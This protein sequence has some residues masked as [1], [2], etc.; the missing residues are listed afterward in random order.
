MRN[1]LFVCMTALVSACGSS[2][3]TPDAAA[4]TTRVSLDTELMDV[5][6][7]D[8]SFVDAI[9]MDASSTTDLVSADVMVTPDG[10][11]EPAVTTQVLASCRGVSGVNET[12][13]LIK[14]ASACTTTRCSKLVVVFAGGEQGCNPT[15]GGYAAVIS[16]YAARGWASIC[17]N[18]FETSDGSAMVPYAAEAPRLD[19][20]MREATTGTWARQYW[21]GEDLLI[22]GISH[23][24]TAPI[25]LMARTTLDNAPHW[26]GTR[27]SGVCMFDGVYDTQAIG[28]FLRTG[29]SGMPC[30]FPLSYTRLLSRYCGAGATEATCNLAT[31]PSAL[32]D[33]VTGVAPSEFA[34]RDFKL[35]ECGSALPACSD[36]ITPRA[37]IEMMCSRLNAPPGSRCSFEALPN[38][39]HLNCHAMEYD[40]C[41]TWFDSL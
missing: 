26:R 41:R 36:D 24:A 8:V 9:R 1:F 6:P 18:Y 10:A 17:I 15:T 19:M 11:R 7:A 22:E 29:R 34:L 25:T 14:N 27:K 28:S 31:L 32:E 30:L 4:D 13:T 40:R 16:S 20:A 12:C 2:T 38:L 21:T 39:S 5:M 37:P 35:F 33:T 23:G 3:P